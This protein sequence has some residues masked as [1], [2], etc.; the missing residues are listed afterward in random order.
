M[1]HRAIEAL[2][3]AGIV[4]QLILITLAFIAGFTA[5]TWFVG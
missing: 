2:N 3:G 5:G 1:I 4:D